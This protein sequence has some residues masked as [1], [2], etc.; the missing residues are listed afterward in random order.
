M[1]C[2]IKGPYSLLCLMALSIQISEICS[3][4]CTNLNLGY[5][6]MG[7]HS[8]AT[9]FGTVEG[10]DTPGTDY[11]FQGADYDKVFGF[12][13]KVT[14]YYQ[15]KYG[16]VVIPEWKRRGLKSKTIKVYGG[17]YRNVGGKC[18]NITIQDGARVGVFVK[19]ASNNVPYAVYQA[20]LEDA[21]MPEIYYYCFYD[22]NVVNDEVNNY[23]YPYELPGDCETYESSRAIITAHVRTK[24]TPIHVPTTTLAP[25]TTTKKTAECTNLNLGYNDMGYHSDATLFGTVE[26]VDTP[27]TDSVFQGQDYDK[28]F[29]F[30]LKVTCYYQNKYGKVVIPEWKRD[31]LKTKTIKV[32]GGGYRNV[33]GQCHNITIQDGERVGIFVK[34]ASN[35]VTYAVY[36]SYRED[37]LM[38]EIHYWCFYDTYVIN[39]EV[40]N[41]CYPNELPGDCTQY[42]SSQTRITIPVKTT[43]S[44]PKTTTKKTAECTNLNLG[45][46]DMGYHSDATLFGTIEGMDTPGTDSVFQGPDY[47]KVFGFNLK[48]TCYYQNKYG[49]VVIPEWQRRGLK[50]KTIKVY[51]GGYRNVGGK[52]HNITIQDGARV[53]IFVKIASNNVPYAVYKAYLEDDLMPEIHYYCF[54][55]TNVVNDEVNNYCYPY[56]LP[57]DC[58]TYESSR[59]IITAHVRTKGTPIHVPTTTLAP[60]TTT[61]K[62]A[63]CTNL[64]LGYN[65]MGYHSD[66]TLFGTVKGVDTPGTDSVFQ[67]PDYDKV[68]GFNLKV[69]CYYQN[70]YG[71]VVIPE[72]KR[73]GLK[74][75]TIKVYGG[76]YRNVGG[77]CHNITIQD[78]ERVGVFVKIA[79]N[80][81]T[82]AVYNSYR[83][84]DLMP[85]IHYWCFY[86]TNVIND[87]VDNYC[88]PNEL[89]GDC[90]QYESS[91]TRITIPVKTTTSAPKTTTKKTAE[92][93]NLNLG[94]NDMGY[95]SDAT[96]FGT[97]EGM[98]T[99]GTDSVFQG[100][101]YDKVFGFNLK[102]TCYYQNKYGK[103]VIPEWQRRG[104]KSKTIK[105]YGGG[106]RNV[107]GK[108]HNITIQDGARVGIFVKIASNNVPYAVYKAYLE[109]D[110]MPEIHYY[111]FYDTNVV[112]DEVNNYCYPYELP[113]DCETYE[114]SRAIITAHV[115]TKGTPI[116][117]PTT[118]LAPKTTTK[119]TAECTNL[120]LGYNDMGYHSDATLFGTVEG[121]DTPGT[122]SVF[123]GQ[124][125]D[126]VFGFNLK[127]TCYYQ[128]KYGKV[129]IPEWKRD[130]LKAK[131]IKV[132]GGGYRNVGGQC[133][134]ITIQDGERVG[135]FVKK[136]S[137]NVTYAVYNSCREDDL[138]PEI[139]YWCFYDTNVINDEVDNF[140]Y[141]NELPGDCAQYESSQAR[142]TIHAKTT[143][144]APKTTTKKTADCANLNLGYNDMGYHSDAALFGTVEGVD[145]PGTDSV[146]QGPDYDKVFGFNLKVTCYYQN[147]Y[148]KVVIPEWKRRGLKSKTIKVYGGGYRN[149]DGQCHNITIQDGARVVVFVK[150]ESNNV[151]YAVYNAYLEDELMPE[152]HYYCFYDTNVINDE[153]NNCYP[154]ELPGDCEIY[155]SSRANITVR[156]KGTPIHVQT[157]TLVPKTTM[158]KTAE[159]TNLKLGYNDMGYHS[160]AT[161]FGNVEG[162]DTPGTDSVFKGPDYDKVFGFNLKVTCYYQNKY[163]K[164]V[165]PEWKRRGL[166]SKT[167]K[168]YGGGY[169]NVGG[170]CHNIT[171]QDGARV[172]VFVKIASNNVT[173]A[174]YN[175]YC[176]DDLMPE[177]HYWC[178]YDTN[179]IN[180]EV[181]NYC[182][183]YELPGD[184]EV[185]ERNRPKITIRTKETQIP[186]QT[187]NSAPNTTAKTTQTAKPTQGRDVNDGKGNQGKIEGQVTDN[188]KGMRI[189]ALSTTLKA[190]TKKIPT[191]EPGYGANDKKGSDKNNPG[192]TRGQVTNNGKKDGVAT[193]S[194]SPIVTTKKTPMMGP[195]YDA[196]H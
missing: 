85:E 11:V 139:H 58:E 111:C 44:A 62:T 190:T 53:G 92:C 89:P 30:N 136:A 173:Y 84:D 176:E 27:G 65:D 194:T 43:T 193:L 170:E 115:R 74:A 94:Y 61:K 109:D 166:I 132:Y 64:N 104:L 14:C 177:I 119:K 134:N 117:V 100:P 46:N 78:G 24:G 26:G 101:D 15:N 45:Y 23:C 172:G 182:Y 164:V 191:T 161:L 55:D 144:S 163:G 12:N 126:K 150:L 158:K 9:L 50:S 143:T 131:T 125:Y 81:V 137:N 68:F 52:C 162:V 184:C 5:N 165:I 180:D 86:D 97:I 174:V 18:H 20:Y 39:D 80:N 127:V 41:Y 146:F 188:G 75:K 147:K 120:N 57:G 135:I 106:Y 48:V 112:N 2:F 95:H 59:A 113:G 67:G 19:I 49:K 154:T 156:T 28:V 121:V 47:D 66:A 169:R 91:Q 183:P 116:H 6:D 196:N 54:Y 145:T 110:L 107:G 16:K 71:K 76:G 153:V 130:G 118:T 37:D 99:P 35:N 187:T 148:G 3:A 63:E 124:D 40:D 13:L 189:N 171:I 34:I 36:N 88:Y 4:E 10:M 60:K 42:E 160:D 141:P 195:G 72:W 167:I 21:L 186:V 83:E 168:V 1:A 96:L 140:C 93:T 8:D 149:V 114:S 178:F 179:V 25:K 123:Q 128:N 51:G 56:E 31:G 155:E 108:C 133:H 77:Q 22:T 138:M 90:T 38:P 7:Y 105:V 69:T 33:G 29:G 98:D 142:I 32:Y 70:K 152:I 17:G 181:D 151:P 129:V 157:T 73:D 192:K 122:D 185:Y 79:S 159:C 82:Y 103:V 87:E 175:A 102:V